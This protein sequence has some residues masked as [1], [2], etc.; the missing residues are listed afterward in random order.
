MKSTFAIWSLFLISG[1]VL[2]GCNSESGPTQGFHI[3]ENATAAPEA[4]VIAQPNRNVTVS[5]KQVGGPGTTLLAEHFPDSDFFQQIEG[6][7][8]PVIVDFTASWC[9]PCQDLKPI[10]EELEQE[11]KVKVVMIDI[12]AN[13]AIASGFGVSPIPHLMLVKDGKIADNVIGFR[14]K[15]A[16]E[17]ILDRL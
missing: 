8:I 4:G 10:L 2:I 14:Q 1:L 16:L 13:P 6:S 15:K 3:P 17:A 5:T 12:D 11:G 7:E 9:G